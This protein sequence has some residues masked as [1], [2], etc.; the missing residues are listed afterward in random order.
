MHRKGLS[1]A[2]MR[3]IL[4]TLLT[5]LCVGMLLVSSFFLIRYFMQSHQEQSIYNQLADMIPPSD[6]LTR[7]DGSAAPA[8]PDYS[9]IFAQNPDTV[10]WL[11]VPGTR[12]NYPV[13]QTPDR[14]NY[15]LHRSFDDKETAAGCPYLQ[16]NCDVNAPSDNLIVYGHNMKSGTMFGDLDLF[17]RRSFW[18]EH[19]TLTLDTLTERRTYEILS[20][21][22][23]TASA[24]D[25]NAFYYHLFVNAGNEADFDAFVAQCKKRSFY[26]TG[27]TASYGDKLITLSTCEYSQTNGRLVVVA[28]QVSDVS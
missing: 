15:Y 26:D 22:K 16:E 6:G 3:R 11:N 23:T 14:P 4:S 2:A 7:P 20:V 27:V 18:E 8:L 21:F 19:R 5:I 25:S 1:N 28:K 12:I 24:D 17:E 9:A 10:G 13:L